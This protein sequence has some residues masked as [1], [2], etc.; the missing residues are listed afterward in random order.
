MKPAYLKTKLFLD[1][2]DPKETEEIKN[3]LGFLDGQT[4]NPSLIA[5]NPDALGKKFSG[6]EIASFYKDV[7]GK[8]SSIIPE[9][10]I[11]IEVYAD[12]NSTSDALLEEG[13]KMFAWIPNAHIKYPIT[14]AGLEAAEKSVK[15][16][17]RVNMTLCFDQ[18]QAAAVYSATSGGEN[19]YVSP[20]AGRWDDKGLNGMDLIKNIL[21]MYV[22]GDG[23]VKVLAASIR[24][25]DHFLCSIAMGSDI[26][27]APFRILKEW[28][29][30]GIPIPGPDYVYPKGSL[31]EIPYQEIELTKPWKEYNITHGMTDAGLERF[32]SDWNNLISIT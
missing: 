7:V 14:K 27:T 13:R 6:D 29:D 12:K 23:H 17:I 26:I 30:K 11:S 5:K 32:S 28:A 8:V 20:F 15:E 24:N 9:G 31:A 25:L 3:L 2:G 18:E 1:S 22:S 10:S 19:A 4:T 21:K 16:E